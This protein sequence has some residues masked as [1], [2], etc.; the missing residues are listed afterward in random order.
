VITFTLTQPV[1]PAL[2]I[3]I[4]TLL[5]TNILHRLALIVLSMV[6]LQAAIVLLVLQVLTVPKHLT[7]LCYVHV[8]IIAQLVPVNPKHVLPA[9]MAMLLD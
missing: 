5:S 1:S 3:P 4:Y 9:L 7:P 6:E 8:D 2:S